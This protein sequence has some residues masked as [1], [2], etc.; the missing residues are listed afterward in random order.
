MNYYIIYTNYVILQKPFKQNNT[1]IKKTLSISSES[2]LFWN[3]FSN[4]IKKLQN[5]YCIFIY[6]IY[7]KICSFYCSLFC[8]SMI[9]S[10]C[11][12]ISNH[13]SLHLCF[14]YKCTFYSI[15]CD[16]QIGCINAVRNFFENKKM[17][18]DRM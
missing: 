12:C 3:L 5:F 6:L 1:K 11:K 10:V 13:L 9:R 17:I 14:M 2:V 16:L 18:D 15:S 8:I 4:Q 7:N